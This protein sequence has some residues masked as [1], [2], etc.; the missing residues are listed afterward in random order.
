MGPG[1]S[2]VGGSCDKPQYW[3]PYRYP[4]PHADPTSIPQAI[5]MVAACLE[6]RLEAA[7]D[8]VVH[9]KLTDVIEP[10]ML[11]LVPI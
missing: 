8:V 1:L 11:R 5:M 6:G 3:Y 7:N 4:C 9:G 2:N 10:K